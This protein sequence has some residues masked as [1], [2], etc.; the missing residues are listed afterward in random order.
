[1]LLGRLLCFATVGVVASPFGFWNL[2]SVPPFPPSIG[3]GGHLPSGWLPPTGVLPPTGIILS[4]TSVPSPMLT[5]DSMA[6]STA[7]NSTLSMV[8]RG[9]D[10]STADSVVNLATRNST[11]KVKRRSFFNSTGGSPVNLAAR[12]TSDLGDR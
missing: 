5:G 11:F 8:K 12:N 10:N 3:R 4:P 2:S 7:Q 9:L 6:N 1:M